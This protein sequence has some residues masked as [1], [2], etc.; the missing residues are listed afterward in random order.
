[1][2]I[3]KLHIII[4][5]LYQKSEEIV[6]QEGALGKDR[7]EAVKTYENGEFIEEILLNRT[8]ITEPTQK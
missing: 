3:L 2:L 4:I 5:Q 6:T 8:R 1:M 7:V